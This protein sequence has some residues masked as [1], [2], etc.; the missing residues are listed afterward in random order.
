MQQSI[1]C[2]F[3]YNPFDVSAA[4]LLTFTVFIASRHVSNDFGI[5]LP[6]DNRFLSDSNLTAN[7][8]SGAR[9]LISL[10]SYANAEK[11]KGDPTPCVKGGV[12]ERSLTIVSFKIPNYTIFIIIQ[13]NT[14]HLRIQKR[15]LLTAIPA[16]TQN[17]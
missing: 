11:V 13:C 4:Q 15:T 16:E 3:A 7:V 2:S 12:A 9:S 14:K 17:K 1:F 8:A 6:R 5:V 10:S